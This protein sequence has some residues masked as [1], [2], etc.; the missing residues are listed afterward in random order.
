MSIHLKREHKKSQTSLT[1]YSST[2]SI[3][4]IFPGNSIHKRLQ[5]EEVGKWVYVSFLCV[6]YYQELGCAVLETGM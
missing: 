3:N 4:H 6:F 1:N 5:G 2:E